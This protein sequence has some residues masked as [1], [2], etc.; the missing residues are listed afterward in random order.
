MKLLNSDNSLQVGEMK[1]QAVL[2]GVK[3]VR[4][5]LVRGSG[6]GV[7]GSRG[8]DN[9]DGDGGGDD[10][11]GDSGSGAHNPQRLVYRSFIS[12]RGFINL[13]GSLLPA[14]SSL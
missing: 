2:V 6:G 1:K 3:L 14:F 4:E 9:D 11:S 10:S 5:V 8:S 12:K 7:G 13:K